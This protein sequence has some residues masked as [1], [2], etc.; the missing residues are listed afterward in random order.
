ML[1]CFLK[2]NTV[3]K[4]V[5]VLLLCAA[6]FHNPVLAKAFTPEALRTSFLYHIAHYTVY[7]EES[8]DVSEFHFCFFESK[9]QNHS[10]VFK[11]IPKKRIKDRNIRLV[12]FDSSEEAEFSRCQLLFVN[13]EAESKELFEQLE[14]LNRTLVSARETR[15]F[16]EK[17]G[18]VTI[19][20]LQS[21]MKIF[22]SHQQY[23][24]T[25]LKFSSLLLK[26]ANFR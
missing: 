26:R 18:M 6:S 2:R 1:F 23:E 11:A 10:E 21:K 22:F 19:V 14:K 25:A 3:G 20:P 13:K 5:T 7:P 12:R 17:G 16:I 15:S 8:L 4:T 24:N 9:N